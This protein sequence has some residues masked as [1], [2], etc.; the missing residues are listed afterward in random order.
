M[1]NLMLAIVGEL[2]NAAANPG[3]VKRQGR[4]ESERLLLPLTEEFSI[5]RR[6]GDLRDIRGHIRWSVC[7]SSYSYRRFGSMFDRS[8][9]E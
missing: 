5:M 3:P 8:R 7:Q 6:N 1:K 4:V 2:R 9:R